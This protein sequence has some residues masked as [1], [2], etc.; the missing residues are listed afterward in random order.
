[1]KRSTGTRSPILLAVALC[2]GAV[3]GVIWMRWDDVWLAMLEWRSAANW[4]RV[5]PFTDVQ[6]DGGEATVVY[7]NGQFSLVSINGVPTDEILA[8]CKRTYGNKWEERFA[9]DIYEVLEELGKPPAKDH[10]VQLVLRDARL[11]ELQAVKSAHMTLENRE[12]VR[13]A[14]QSRPRAA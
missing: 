14:R 3:I 9:E 13:T 6:C 5:S 11:G 12:A 7:E 10:V 2:V 1:M 4:R 8:F